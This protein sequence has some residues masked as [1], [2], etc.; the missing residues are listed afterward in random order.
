MHF[1]HNRLGNLTGNNVT[2]LWWSFLHK[3]H[4]SRKKK[5][6]SGAEEGGEEKKCWSSSH[7]APAQEERKPFLCFKHCMNSDLPI[8]GIDWFT[9]APPSDVV[10]TPPCFI[11]WI[12]TPSSL[13]PR[14]TDRRRSVS[15]F[16]ASIIIYI[17]LSFLFQRNQMETLKVWARLKGTE[18]T[19]GGGGGRGGLLGARLAGM[20]EEP[21]SC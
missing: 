4:L 21:V 14:E 16:I 9:H 20:Q 12:E 1:K 18:G 6:K 19:G 8:P 15:A 5:K 13:S 3:C 11:V 7:S 10:D 2:G 17:W